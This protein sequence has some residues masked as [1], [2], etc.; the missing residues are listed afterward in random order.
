MPTTTPTPWPCE[1]YIGPVDVPMYYTAE[2]MAVFEAR[3]PD[4]ITDEAYGRQPGP[5]L[6]IL[7]PDAGQTATCIDCGRDYDASCSAWMSATR[8]CPQC[9]SRRASAAKARKGA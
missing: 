4:I 3:E 5:R 1:W 7:R 2:E 6:T 8:R 9:R